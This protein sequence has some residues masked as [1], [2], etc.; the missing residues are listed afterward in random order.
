MTS[1][2][3]YRDALSF[4][5]VLKYFKE[6]GKNISKEFILDTF[7]EFLTKNTDL[8]NRAMENFEELWKNL[9]SEIFENANLKEWSIDIE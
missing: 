9:I 5:T 4:E 6:S 7:I 1:N 2:R 3:P 8:I